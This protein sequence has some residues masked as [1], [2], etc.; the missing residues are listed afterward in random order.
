MKRRNLLTKCPEVDQYPLHRLLHR[1][2]ASTET[3]RQENKFVAF[4]MKWKRRKKKDKKKKKGKSV[5]ARLQVLF[6][7]CVKRT[8][9]PIFRRHS[10][11]STEHGGREEL[12]NA[13]EAEETFRNSNLWQ[14]VDQ[15]PP[16]TFLFRFDDRSP[17][18][19]PFPTIFTIV[20]PREQTQCFVAWKP[21]NAELEQFK[22]FVN[23]SFLTR[24]ST[25]L[26]F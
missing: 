22:V 25:L 7:I 2:D 18:N 9:S 17:P 13:E 21:R 4:E 6:S 14:S 10:N 15:S 3:L 12:E 26:R 8:L 23:N 5:N 1:V 20:F 11:N 19:C 24:E 16:R